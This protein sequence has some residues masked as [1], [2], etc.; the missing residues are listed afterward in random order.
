MALLLAVFGAVLPLQAGTL[1]TLYNFTFGPKNPQASLMLDSNGVFHATSYAGGT[2]GYGTIFAATTNGIL[3]NLVSFAYTNGA[4]P[5]TFLT[6]AVPGGPNYFGTTSAGGI[7]DLGVIFELTNGAVRALV[8]FNATNGAYPDSGLVAANGWLYGTTFGGGTV[9]YGRL[10]GFGT[11]FRI[12]TNGGNFTTLV[13]FALSNGSNPQGPLLTG[14]DGNFYG[15][16]LYGGANDYGTVYQM[17]PGGSLTS[18]ASFNYLN[19]AYPAGSLIEVSNLFYG[20]TTGGGSSSNGTV[21]V[22]SPAGVLKTLVSFNALDGSDPQAGLVQG[23]DGN[24]YGTTYAG[25]I[26]G[27][28]TIFRI[29]IGGALTTILNFNYINGANPQGTLVKDSYGNLY[30]ITAYGGPYNSGLIFKVS[31]NGEVSTVMYLNPGAGFPST[32]L[33]PAPG[34]LFYCGV[35]S[36]GPSNNASVVS[37]N[38][39]GLPGLIAPLNGPNDANPLG[40]L[41]LAAD[42]NYYGTTFNGGAS[43]SGS[44]FKLSPQGLIS[45]IASFAGT[46]GSHPLGGLVQGSDD[47]LYGTTSQGGANNTGTVFK[48]TPAETNWILTNAAVTFTT[49]A[50][51]GNYSLQGAAFPEGPLAEGPGSVYYGTTVDG[52]EYGYGTIFSFTTNGTLNT[53]ASFTEANGSYPETGLLITSNGVAFGTTSSGGAYGYGTVFALS[54]NGVITNLLFFDGLD[55]DDPQGPL[56]SGPGGNFYGTTQS[57]GSLGYGTV[58]AISPSGNLF[59]NWSFNLSDGASPAGGLAVIQGNVYGTASQGGLYGAGTAFELWNGL[60]LINSSNQLS[61]YWSTNVTGL[62]LQATTNLTNPA[63]WINQTNIGTMGSQ[64]VLTNSVSLGSEFFRLTQP[65]P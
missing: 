31:P 27:E 61:T 24:L 35:G 11:I 15:T 38:V 22:M 4:A 58:F 55:G 43:G 48:I 51:F 26:N 64:F 42:G 9:D 53:I 7:N 32:G 65:T 19:G 59:T 5:E 6:P 62:V 12:S 44:V 17:T 57:G 45:T 10:V 25:G 47:N 50:S 63:G 34:G 16:T 54:P 21:Y 46:N 8:S 1:T 3:T 41:T 36:G 33:T 14:A 40:N 29:S 37:L 28:G 30:G 13:N 2:G 52:G 56:V 23:N 18:L 49:L 39:F 20:T 60:S